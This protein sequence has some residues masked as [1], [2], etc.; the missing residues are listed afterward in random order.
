MGK[1]ES[2][3]AVIEARRKNE[4]KRPALDFSKLSDDD[5]DYIGSL[6]ELEPMLCHS[7]IA[8]MSEAEIEAF[9]PVLTDEQQRRVDCIIEKARP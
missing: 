6:G 7:E 1:L 3:L 9:M 5:W 4:P 8:A 2:R